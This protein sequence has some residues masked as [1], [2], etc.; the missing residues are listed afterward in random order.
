[1]K[2]PWSEPAPIDYSGEIDPG[3]IL[4]RKTGKHYLHFSKGVV[5][6]LSR[7]GL[8]AASGPQKVYDGWPYPK[9]WPGEGFCLES[10]KLF[11][12]N[13]YYY[14]CVAQGGTAGPPTSHM[15]AA[16]RSKSPLGPW[17]NSPYNPIVHTAS[18]REHWWSR[19][20]GP[21]VEGPDG[22]W[23]VIYH[24]YEKNFRTLGRQTLLEP[25]EWT[26][27]GWFRI[28]RGTRPE[29]PLK[30]PGRGQ[31]VSGGLALSDDFKG[32]ELGPQWASIGQ[33][34]PANFTLTGDG[35]VMKVSRNESATESTRASRDSARPITLLP[36]EIALL[37][38]IPINHSYEA[39]VRLQR[40]PGVEAGLLLYYCPQALAGI[41]W[42]TKG[43][44]W[45][46][47]SIYRRSERLTQATDSLYLKVVNRENVVTLFWRSDHAQWT[48]SEYA[49][50]VSGYH[51]NVFNGYG[52]LRV[53]LYASGEGSVRFSDF[54][55][56]G[57]PDEA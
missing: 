26:E 13:G 30:K 41:G 29:Q 54:Q 10:P 56:R 28:P 52:G 51:H 47:G 50:E 35:L 42:G 3:Y 25:I 12:R 7:D 20:H 38:V 17:E 6:E 27:D 37:A 32:K 55:Y 14:L 4:D 2:G 24:A 21:V 5:V 57:L 11:Y 46:M 22:N 45:T 19:G 18:Q 15:L 16:A 48:Q 39:Q 33:H 34:D 53:A 8:Q 23:W 9:E 1:M 31:I 44:I 36:N 49:H 43:E 40:E